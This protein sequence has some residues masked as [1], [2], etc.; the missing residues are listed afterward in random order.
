[1]VMREGLKIMGV[2]ILVIIIGFVIGLLINSGVIIVISI[3][4]GVVTILGGFSKF[5]GIT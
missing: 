1:M 5:I 3:V 2:G 4:I